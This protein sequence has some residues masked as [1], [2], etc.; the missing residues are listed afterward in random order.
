M[1]RLALVGLA[2]I[3]S[4]QAFAAPLNVLFIAI[5]DLRPELGCYGAKHIQSPNIDRLAQRGLLFERAYCQQAVCNPSRASILSGCRPDTTKV[6]ANNTFMRPMMPDVV[7]LP[8]HFKNNGWY[9]VSLGK[10]F[11]HSE[12]EP[13]NDPLSWSEPAWFHGEPFQHWFSKESAEEIKRLKKLPPEQRPKLIRPAPFEAAVEPD[14]SY[15]DAQTAAKAIETLQRLKAMEKPFFL[16]VG[17]VK[18]HLPF[19]APQKYWDLYPAETIKLPPNYYPTKGAPEAAFHNGYE[20]R[21]YGGIPPKGGISDE[22][23]L[24]LIRG[25][26]ACTTFM[27]VQVGRVLDELDRL[28]LRENTIVVFWGDHGYHLGE[29]G[30]FTKMTNFELGT[31]VPLIVSAPGMKTAG[32]RTRALVELVDLYPTLAELA[33]LSKPLHLE[34]RSFAPLLADPAQPWKQAAFSQ[35]LR[36]GPDRI[37]GRS[38][39]T[40]RWRYTEWVNGKNESVGNEL[41]DEEGDPQENVN[42]VSDPKNAPV[43]AQL[44]A[45]LHAGWKAA[46][47]GAPKIAA[48]TAPPVAASVALSPAPPQLDGN[49]VLGSFEGD[50]FDGWTA[51]GEAFLAKPYRPGAKQRLTEYEGEGVAWSGSGGVESKGALLSPE[52]RV[53]KKFL[54][55]LIEGPRDVPGILGAELL[56]ENRVVRAGSATEAKDPTH[57]LHWRTW[58]VADL[59]GRTA[60][61]RVNDQSAGGAVAVDQFVQS[62]EAKSVPIDAAVLGAESHRPQFHFTT[63][64]GWQNDA[65]GLFYYQG[66]WHLFHQHRPPPGNKIMWGHA[67]SRDLLHWQR[68][69]TTIEADGND[70]AASGS[71]LVDWENVSGLKRGEHPPILLFYTE[72]PP[73]GGERKATQCMAVSTDG[74][75]TFEKF[76]GNP[77]LRTPAT[78]DRDPKVFFHQPTRSWIMALSLSRNNTDRENATY[79]LFRSADLKSWELFQEL[80]PGSWYWECPDMFELPIDGDPARKKWIF[81]KGSGDYLVGTFDGKKFTPETEP[82]RIHWHNTFYGAQSFSDA[83]NGRRVQFG[84]MSTGADGPK[85]WP[86]MPFNQQMSFP[87]ELTLRSTPEGPRIFRQPVAEITQLYTKTHELGARALKPG[88]NALAGIPAGLLDIELEIDL[89]Q[90]SR[91]SLQCRG[92]EV[93]HEVKSR[94]LRCLRAD[95]ALTLQDGRLKLRVLIDRTS[96]EVFAND[97]DTDASGV[98]F[99]DMA[100]ASLALSV[101]GGAAQ[102]R[103]L[104]VRELKSIWPTPATP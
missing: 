102:I 40:D 72:M 5:D 12:K 66:D 14:A 37:M 55:F 95:P 86:G 4:V 33:G 85:S 10:I 57:A 39:R 52:F 51:T 78:R 75:R 43:V 46:L 77:L 11:H 96:I 49:L 59:R 1:S 26:R 35:Y 84:W 98:Y 60:R 41:Y 30:L 69:P 83:P 70:A 48:A 27:D 87:R 44:V 93:S 24:N 90:A 36:P 50:S 100:D 29:N 6:M 71:G 18:P 79:G 42:I 62:G 53:E 89:Q 104:V 17:F 19:T 92:G 64:T 34:G 25:Y 103:R 91:F 56:V 16:G 13:G 94:K 74:A 20:L 2:L 45:Q 54:N 28:G 73:A 9:S 15:P 76:P 58:D 23:A 67:T 97:G 32:Q 22:T 68:L 65:N 21:S 63:L 101:E 31:H 38:V 81:M 47:P 7:S 3:F 8:Q 88:E 80:G 82:I 61:I 99:P